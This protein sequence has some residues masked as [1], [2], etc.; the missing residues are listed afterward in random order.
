[1]EWFGVDLGSIWDRFGDRFGVRIGL[2]SIWDRFGLGSG[3]IWEK[4]GCVSRNA[5]LPITWQAKYRASMYRVEHDP[6]G[7]IPEPP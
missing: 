7:M 5:G 2:G 4:F 3:S 6:S 1:M